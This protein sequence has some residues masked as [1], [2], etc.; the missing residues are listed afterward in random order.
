MNAVLVEDA[1]RVKS[2]NT[3]LRDVFLRRAVLIT[4]AENA[5]VRAVRQQWAQLTQRTRETLRM[6]AHV[7]DGSRRAESG[8]LD[9]IVSEIH[10]HILAALPA[11]VGCL[12]DDLPLLAELQLRGVPAVLQREL[13]RALSA[14][15]E[16]LDDDRAELS[17]VIAEPTV[18]LAS[19]LT[20]SFSS[21]PTQQVAGLFSSPL[22]GATYGNSFA[23]LA[24]GTLRA[25]RATLAEGLLRGD[26]VPTVTRRVV[27]VLDVD[28]WKAERIVRTEYVRVAN[29]AAMLVF[30]QNKRLLRGVQWHA[31]LDK[32]TCPQCGAL[33]GRVWT[34]INKARRSPLH[35]SCRCVVIPLIKPAKDL[36]LTGTGGTR[37]SF[38]GQVPATMT[39]TRWFAQ[40]DAA[41]QRGVLGPTRYTLYASGEKALK[42]FSTA[43]GLVPIKS[44]VRQ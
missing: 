41:F 23:D 12:D 17:P 35:P 22:G 16:A 7:F 34:D 29:D 42:D 27:S 38:D 28:R 9:G 19:R 11:L 21:V 40:Q 8:R 26:G 25:L 13:D 15:Q 18:P 37:Q 44:L 20:V 14:T 32:R 5:C 33:D 30:D 3:R 43:R 1:V 10:V 2:I 6:H 31:T 4:R 24:A 36:G 39:Y